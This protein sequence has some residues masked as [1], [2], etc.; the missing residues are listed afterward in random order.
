M[1]ILYKTGGGRVCLIFGYRSIL[2]WFE[3]PTTSEKHS[4]E[5][6]LVINNPPIAR[7]TRT[8]SPSSSM[9]M[10]KLAPSSLPSL[11]TS[12]S[13]HARTS[14]GT[15]QRSAGSSGYFLALSPSLYTKVSGSS[16][17]YLS[18]INASPNK[19]PSSTSSFVGPLVSYAPSPIREHHVSLLSSASPNAIDILESVM[20]VE[21]TLEFRGVREGE[22]LGGGA[23]WVLGGWGLEVGRLCLLSG[24]RVMGGEIVDV[25]GEGKLVTRVIDAGQGELLEA[26]LERAIVEHGREGSQGYGG[27]DKGLRECVKETVGMFDVREEGGMFDISVSDTLEEEEEEEEA[28]EKEKVKMKEKEKEKSPTVLSP[29]AL[30]LQDPAV[31]KCLNDTD[32]L[33]ALTALFSTSEGKYPEYLASNVR[34]SCR[35]TAGVVQR[36]VSFCKEMGCG[37]GKGGKR[38]VE[39][40]KRSLEMESVVEDQMAKVLGKERD[41][42]E[43]KL[44]T[45]DG[46]GYWE[47]ESWKM[48]KEEVEKIVEGVFEGVV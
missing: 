47:W 24:C 23:S 30:L 12:L 20:T 45:T 31:L 26:E 5:C 37:E 25:I 18:A 4:E 46:E 33:F 22:A 39:A 17:S 48:E 13:A 34:Q 11:L 40:F 43:R 29:T 42:R 36:Q 8:P 2:S 7:I 41:R 6:S 10:L 16:K 27:G 32:P 1:K 21:N 15:L 3:S 35:I 44:D 19:T 14:S 9:T 28:G 38:D